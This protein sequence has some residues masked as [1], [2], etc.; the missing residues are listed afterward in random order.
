MSNLFDSRSIKSMT[1]AN[2]FVR[3]ATWEGMAGDDGSVTPRLIGVMEQLA[4]G[5]VG[6][7]ITSHAYVSSEGQAGPYQL[8]VSSDGHVS[9]LAA[10]VKSVHALGGRI[11]LQIAHAGV[12]APQRFSGG[13]AMGPSV[14]GTNPEA[15]GRE[16]VR[17]DMETVARAFA[18]AAERARKAG[19]DAVQIHAAHGYLL[20]QF[21]SPFYNKRKDEYGGAIENRV[22]LVVEVLQAIRQTVGPAFPVLIK[23]NSEDFLEGGLTVE[24]MLRTAEMLEKAGIDAVEM[25]GGTFFSGRNTPSRVGKADPGEPEAFYEAAARRYKERVGAPLMLVGGIRSL[26]TAERLVADGITDTIALCRPLI[27]EPGLI[28]RWKGGDRRP[29]L[30]VSDNGCFKPALAGKG[31]YCVVDARERKKAPVNGGR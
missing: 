22:K 26:E 4:R 31:I 13:R 10:M 15:G 16:M 3:S 9:G 19:F 2:G 24:D 18:L 28:N 20:S 7:I 29:A 23:L 12:R 21:L 1:L 6:L 14:D 27:R 11:A 25:S 8:G 30:C 5:G 17:A